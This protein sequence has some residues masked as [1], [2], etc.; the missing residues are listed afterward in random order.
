MRSICL[1]GVQVAV[2]REG[3]MILAIDKYDY[4]LCYRACVV[5]FVECR[6]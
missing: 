6:P 5:I 2:E 1:I 4:G 3:W